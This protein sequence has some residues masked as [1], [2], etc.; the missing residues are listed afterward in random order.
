MKQLT[1]ILTILPLTLGA[2]QNDIFDGA[3]DSEGRGVME[4]ARQRIEEIRKGDFTL[5]LLDSNGNPI[6]GSVEVNHVEHEFLFG[7]NASA[8]LDRAKERPMHAGNFVPYERFADWFKAK[9]PKSKYP[10]G[11]SHETTRKAVEVAQ[12]VT[13]E[14]FNIIT[15]N[16]HW[17]DVQPSLESVDYSKIDEMHAWAI[18]NGLKTRMHALV[19]LHPVITPSWSDQVQTTEEWWELIEKRIA[20]IAQ[21]YSHS[22]VEYDVINETLYQKNNAKKN[23]PLFPDYTSPETGTRLFHIARRHLPTATL[24]PLDQVYPVIFERNQPFRTYLDYCAQMIKMGAPIDAIGY[25]AHFW[26]SRSGAV[27]KSVHDGLNVGGPDAFKMAALEKGLDFM[28]AKLNKPIHI[29]EFNPPSRSALNP[30][31]D[32]PGL[33]EVELTRWTRNFY[34]LV[35]SKAYMREITCWFVVDVLG[36]ASLD[37]GLVTLEGEKKPLYYTL[38]KLIKEDW[39]TQWSG[40]AQNGQVSLRGF[41]GHY[42]VKVPGYETARIPL[43]E[44][45][46]HAQTL[47]LK[48]SNN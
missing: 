30:D 37:P 2:A 15:I 20:E 12:E 3:N 5:T 48:K 32:Q 41:W 46:P 34:T 26:P 40:K 21:R 36:G 7:G 14:L 33:T 27:T 4:A 25:Q 28:A 19:Y 38:K 22:Y 39:S 18:A 44:N 35:F 42:E 24:M 17:G 23:V 45:G 13:K 6:Q 16:C 8:F 11:I 10:N 47:W 9:Y 1:L 29:T 43:L 31:P